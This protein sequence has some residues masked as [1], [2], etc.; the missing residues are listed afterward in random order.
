MKFSLWTRIFRQN[1][2]F[3]L[4]I[5]WS[6]KNRKFGNFSQSSLFGKKLKFLENWN[7]VFLCNFFWI[8]IFDQNFDCWRKF[9]FRLSFFN[10]NFHCWLKNRFLPVNFFVYFYWNSNLIFCIFSH[11]TIFKLVLKNTENLVLKTQ[12]IQKKF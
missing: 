4:F 3:R 6:F 1:L 7:Y 11:V 2:F 12:K 5:F 8:W 9:I 10:Q